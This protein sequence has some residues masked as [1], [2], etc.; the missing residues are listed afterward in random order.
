[1]DPRWLVGVS[2]Y[3][4]GV[5]LTVGIG[6]PIPILNEEILSYTAIPDEEIWAPVVDYSEAYPQNKPEVL[7]EVN[8]KQLKSGKVAIQG[9]EVP[10]APLSSYSRALEVARILKEWIKAGKFLLGEPVQTLPSA[11]SGV[12][13]RPL[14]ERP[15]QD[16]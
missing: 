16:Q 9:K 7:A 15:V 1:M 14:K 5:S 8:Y 4:Y 10:S 6:V 11:D 12:S 2:F 3:G 13:F